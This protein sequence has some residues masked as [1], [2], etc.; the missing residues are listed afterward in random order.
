MSQW[1]HSVILDCEK[2]L[3]IAE[4]IVN[5]LAQNFLHNF[6]EKSMKVT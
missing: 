1:L 4:I 2:K 5:K 3:A 6:Q